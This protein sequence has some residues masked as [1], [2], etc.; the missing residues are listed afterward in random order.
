[1]IAE[2]EK[3]DELVLGGQEIMQTIDDAVEPLNDTVELI[4][5]GCHELI[6]DKQIKDNFIASSRCRFK[7]NET[8]I[9][10][11]LVED[12]VFELDEIQKI[13]AR[14]VVIVYV[15]QSEEEQVS[16]NKSDKIKSN[17][18]VVSKRSIDF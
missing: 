5:M 9:K 15:V 12:T 14:P 6:E 7:D 16:K 8:L 11:T 10:Q 4:L 3:L 17:S 1:M 18:I 2:R 13:A